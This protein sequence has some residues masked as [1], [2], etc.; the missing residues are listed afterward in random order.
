[1]ARLRVADVR[2]ERTPERVAVRVSLMH[3]EAALAAEVERPAAEAQGVV[4]AAEAALEAVRQ[5][6][7][8]GTRWGLQQATKQSVAAGV[9]VVVNIVLET[10]RGREHLVGSAFSRAGPLEEIAAHAVVDAVERRL[11]GFL[12]A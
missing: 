11:A 8:P 3:G 4:V 1:M 6:V 2:V 7:P 9:A 12:R 5:A 10:E